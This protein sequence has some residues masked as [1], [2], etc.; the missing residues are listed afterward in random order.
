M[1]FMYFVLDQIRGIKKST[2][3]LMCVSSEVMSEKMDFV[4]IDLALSDSKFSEFEFE[5][6][7]WMTKNRALSSRILW[8][9]W[10]SHYPHHF[11]GG[12]SHCIQNK[13]GFFTELGEKL[14][15]IKP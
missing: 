4:I 10:F 6:D 5:A 12:N 13:Y 8:S 1:V 2:D 15:L 14:K 11:Y 9:W 7:L 3:W